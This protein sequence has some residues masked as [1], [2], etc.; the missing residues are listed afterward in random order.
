M[1]C[2]FCG[3]LRNLYILDRNREKGEMPMHDE[4]GVAIT[5]DTYTDQ[6]HRFRG[7]TINS[8]FKLRFCPECGADIKKRFRLWRNEADGKEMREHPRV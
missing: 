1:N 4:Y 6:G 5:V 8:G 7:R 3:L 2:D